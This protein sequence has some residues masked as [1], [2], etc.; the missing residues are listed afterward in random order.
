MGTVLEASTEER[1]MDL[2]KR[3][4]L[5][6]LVRGDAL[7]EIGADT[8]VLAP[9]GRGESGTFHKLASSGKSSSASLYSASNS[10]VVFRLGCQEPCLAGRLLTVAGVRPGLQLAVGLGLALFNVVEGLGEG[11]RDRLRL[12][13]AVKA[14]EGLEGLLNPFRGPGTGRLTEC[15]T[16]WPFVGGCKLGWGR[17]FPSVVSSC[18]VSS[19]IELL[20]DTFVAA[21]EVCIEARIGFSMPCRLIGRGFCSSSRSISSKWMMSDRMPSAPDREEE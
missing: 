4:G 5:S 6:G 14:K 21:E 1:P 10:S 13:M 7:G 16:L 20:L 2:R 17:L 11:D 19:N 15:V 12:L 8:G 3:L 18:M 9:G